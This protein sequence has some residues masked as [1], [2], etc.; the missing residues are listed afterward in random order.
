[1]TRWSLFAVCR[2][3]LTACR[4]LV[5]ISSLLFSVFCFLFPVY[6]FLNLCN[7]RNLRITLTRPLSPVT[8]HLLFVYPRPENRTNHHRHKFQRN[9]FHEKAFL[10]K[11][12][13]H[14]L[15]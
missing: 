10:V 3:L 1:M 6:F 14:P 15:D 7:P 8:R 5:A 2:L 12:K 13:R 9:N 11:R 4:L